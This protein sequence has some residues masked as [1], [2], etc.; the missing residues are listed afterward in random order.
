[1]P[2]TYSAPSTARRLCKPPIIFIPG[3]LG[4]RLVNRRTG[5]VL[6]PDMSVDGAKLALPISAP[7]PALNTDDVVATEIVEEA[8][9]S[10]MIPEISVYGPLL[11]V[12]ER[13]GG[14][15]RARFDAPPPGGDCDTL[16]VFPYDWRR[17]LVESA[18][19]LAFMIEELK[20]RLGRPDL[21]FD[22]VA[23]SMG[24]LIAR[25][26]AMYGGRDVLDTRTAPDWSG[27]LNLNKIVM[28]ATPNGGSMNAL[29]ALLKGF[30]AA[31]FAKTFKILPRN[32][33]NKLPIGR[34]N[35]RVTFTS[36]AIYQLLPPQRQARFFDDELTPLQIQLYDVETWRRF[37]WSAAFDESSRRHEFRRTIEK[38]GW[39]VAK[40]ERLRLAAERERY[41]R[42][43]LRRAAAFHDAMAIECPPPVNLRFSFIGGDCFPTLDGAVIID[44]ASPRTIFHT[45]DFPGDKSSR[46]KAAEL[47]FSPGDG[48][49]T[50]HS[51]L[52]R[53]LEALPAVAL[54]IAMRSIYVGTT[55]SCYSH[56]GILRDKD[57]QNSL[58]LALLL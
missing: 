29:R 17:D 28:I 30:S 52:G 8:K 56:N 51:L 37:K 15:R 48:T 39:S 58:L 5:E 50:R 54:P 23:H 57:M 42:V 46:R 38:Q 35:T 55:L 45:A 11:E 12:L 2:Q 14:Y 41:L 47:I 32:L 16:Y 7:T 4:S 31:S 49:I 34:L 53:P 26:Y 22:I 6:W 10:A 1:L 33:R 25:Y 18:R 20:R 27:A 43:V 21:R 40:A 13:N 9:V 44:R 3:I 36:P 24:G 19:S